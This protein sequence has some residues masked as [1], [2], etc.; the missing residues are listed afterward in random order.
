MAFDAFR[1]LISRVK[2]KPKRE[3]VV[4]MCITTPVMIAE[5]VKISGRCRI[6]MVL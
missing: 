5:L 2:I 1:I 4:I 3:A 6:L